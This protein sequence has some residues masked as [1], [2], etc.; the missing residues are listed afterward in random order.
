MARLRSLLT[1]MAA[2]LDGLRGRVLPAM[3][4]PPGAALD[5][6]VWCGLLARLDAATA[7]EAA[8]LGPTLADLVPLPF[9]PGLRRAGAA[10]LPPAA[11]WIM[12]FD[13]DGRVREAALRRLAG[14][15][16]SVGR[17]T[18]LAVRLN[19]WAPQVRTAA[20]EALARVG[21]LTPT[22]VIA[23][24]S[25]FLLARR[26]A[27]KRGAEEALRLD[28]VFGAAGVAAAVADRLRDGRSGPLG[29]VLA[30][31]LRLPAYDAGLAELAHA[32]RLP[33]VRATA[34]MA[35]F[36]QEAV[37]PAGHGWAWVDKSM[38]VRRRVA[39]TGRRAVGVAE[40]PGLLRRALADRS[41]L[42]RKAAADVVVQRMHA[43]PDLERLTDALAADRSAAVRDRADYIFRQLAARS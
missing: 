1:R 23:D 6:P 36:R 2:R 39:L 27:W 31:A 32:A 33:D 15:A 10:R 22:G 37:W 34:A 20:V 41:A 3:A 18:A 4:E 19:D 7:Q 24:A 35:L 25:V 13:R 38:G 12:S 11:D 28:D 9:D 42:V 21:P 16:S 17:F 26:L 40:P 14:P 30:H 29:R 5:E 8:G 43:L